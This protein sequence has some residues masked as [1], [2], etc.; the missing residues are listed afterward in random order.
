GEFG[1][2]GTVLDEAEGIAEAAGD[3]RSLGHALTYKTMQFVHGGDLAAAFRTGRRA[4]AIGE[5]QSVVA[6]QVFAN[7]YLGAACGA[8]GD[9]REAVRHCEAAMSLIPEELRQERFG[10]TSIVSSSARWTLASALGALGRFP[11]AL[12]RLREAMQIAEEAGHVWTL[13]FP[14][15]G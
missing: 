13:L 6:I 3:Q 1:R 7:W 9:W 12:G 4:L 10:Q 11:E 14:L 8:G 5:S 2:L 15:I